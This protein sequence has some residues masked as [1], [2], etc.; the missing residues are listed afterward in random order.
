MMDRERFFRAR[1]A[2]L[3][4][5][6]ENGGIGTLGE[7]ALHAILK[8]YLDENPL[9]HEQKFRGFFADV[10][11]DDGFFEIQTRAFERLRRKL[12]VFMQE[13]VTTVVYPIA[14]VRR[15]SWID[16]ATHALSPKRKSPKTGKLADVAKELY[17]IRAY[18]LHPKFR[19]RVL[20]LDCD[21]YKKKSPR[22]RRVEKCERIPYELVEDILFS[23]PRDYE[24][25]L[26]EE[27]P[28]PFTSTDLARLLKIP[29]STAGTLLL[30]LNDLEVVRRIGKQGNAYLYEKAP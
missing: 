20:M 28:A 16:P 5:D 14:R 27:L 25:L 11:N 10:R 19:L 13:S 6:G 23:S 3:G 1:S 17:R 24:K 7:K 8:Y 22:G 26:P 15:L 21:E 18:L 9:N 30:L 4:G 29:R 12:D 2:V